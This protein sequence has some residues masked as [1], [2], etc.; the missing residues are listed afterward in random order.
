MK[1]GLVFL[2]VP[3]QLITDIVTVMKKKHFFYIENL[4]VVNLDKKLATEV[5]KKINGNS[6]TNSVDTGRASR[7]KKS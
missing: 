2:W 3:K 6:E 1:K 7:S 4:E 5:V